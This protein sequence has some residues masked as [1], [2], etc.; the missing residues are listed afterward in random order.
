[1]STALL[2]AIAYFLILSV[3]TSLYLRKKIKTGSDFVTGGGALA[4]PLVMAGFVLAPLGSGHTLSL[5]E[6]SADKGASVLWWGIMSGGLMVPLFLLW[7]GPWFRRL[8]VQTFPEGMGKIFG[9]N[10]GW[11]ISA[12]FPAQLI[13][14]CIAE[15]T[16]T[17]TAFYALGGRA[18][19]FAPD[20]AANLFSFTGMFSLFKGLFTLNCISLAIGFTI[21]YIF[22]GGLAQAA[23]MNIINAVMLILGSFIA[24]FATGS[25]LSG[26]GGWESISNFYASAGVPWK[27]SILNFSPDVIFTLILPCLILTIFMQSASQ[28]Q[29]QPMLLAR[30]EADIRRGT[31][32]AAFINSLAAYP[33]VI[34]GLVGMAIPAIAIK[35]AKLSLPELALMALPQWMIGLLM[36]ALLAAT[37]ST[38]GGLILGAAHII[39]HDIFKRAVHPKMS[40][41]TFLILTRITILVCAFLVV[42]PALKLPYIF[43][44]FMWTFSFAIPVFG[45][46]LIG[47]VWK[48]NKVAAW[49]TIS[50]GYV[51]N[52]LWTFAQPN[53]LPSYLSLNVYPTTFATLI[54]GIVLN[55]ILPGQPA[56]LR[57][58]KAQQKTNAVETAA[59]NS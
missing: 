33:W 48:V 53:W 35:G 47:M 13:G 12:V 31:F 25:W 38:T 45:A 50:A 54:F 8:N 49:V 4:W 22:V 56:Y 7:F 23:W 21:L 42:I 52:F 29:N 30:S 17:A 44:I 51:A 18:I 9:E 11:M 5:W 27:T 58:L 14:I 26:R 10:I 16:A 55:L 59:T 2:I 36:I 28:V 34:L 20:V 41:S 15:V 37:L 46:Y 57:Q 6:S 3:G 19:P 39:V 40:D 32:W 24:V 43:S 1:M